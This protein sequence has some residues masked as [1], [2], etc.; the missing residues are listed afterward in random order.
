MTLSNSSKN[1]F[2]LHSTVTR[3]GR[4]KDLVIYRDTRD[5]IEICGYYLEHG[6]ER[7]AI[8]Q[9]G[10]ATLAQNHTFVQR[11]IDMLSTVQSELRGEPGAFSRWY[12]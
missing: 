5:L 10:R 6:E 11:I 4:L 2:A 3:N 7:R 1:A 9:Q 12:H 8:A